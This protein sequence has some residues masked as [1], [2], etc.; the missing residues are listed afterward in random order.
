MPDFV[1]GGIAAPVL[2]G[3]PFSVMSGIGFIATFGVAILDRVVFASCTGEERAEGKDSQEA[4]Q[5]AAEMRLRPW[6]ITVLMTALVASIGFYPWPPRPAP[7][8]R[9]NGRLRSS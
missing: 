3:M 6:L 5:K 7:G 1:T 2:R 8:R 4:A 9:C